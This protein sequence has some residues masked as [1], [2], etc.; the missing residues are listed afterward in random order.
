M[1][2][3]GEHLAAMFLPEPR[4]AL[5]ARFP[6]ELHTPQG[7]PGVNPVLLQSEHFC[8]PGA[9]LWQDVHL[10]VPWAL[11]P[12]HPPRFPDPLQSRHLRFPFPAQFLQL[13]EPVPW[14]SWQAVLA[15]G[16]HF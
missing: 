1:P 16:S 2:S 12:A 11:Q 9:S 14:H 6:L 7:V 15:H 4:Q 13:Y 10:M 5:Q 8:F 3:Q